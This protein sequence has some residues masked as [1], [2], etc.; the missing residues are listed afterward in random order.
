MKRI[1]TKKVIA[2]TRQVMAI[3]S[4]EELRVPWCTR[5]LQILGSIMGVFPFVGVTKGRPEWQWMSLGVL[6]SLSNLAI[7]CYNLADL[8][9]GRS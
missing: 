4:L 9:R 8:L 6:F 7:V 3:E 5:S 2:D 1:F